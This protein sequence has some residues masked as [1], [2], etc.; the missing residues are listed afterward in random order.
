MLA[1]IERTLSLAEIYEDVSGARID[2][3]TR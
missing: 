3:M 1:S 2:T